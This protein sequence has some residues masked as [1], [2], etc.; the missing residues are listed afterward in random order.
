MVKLGKMNFRFATKDDESLVEKFCK[1]QN[2]S[3]NT[4]LKKMKWEWVLEEGAWTVATHK[5]KI[6]SIAGIHKL[7]EVSPDAYRCLFR[8]AQLPGYTLGTGRDIFK[9][10]IQLSQLLNLQINWA[11]EQNL[12]AEL[13][14][15]TN[16]NDDGGKSKR[17]NDTMMPLLARRGIWKLEQSMM[18]FNV[19][20]RL[21]RINVLKYME[22]RNLSLG[23]DNCTHQK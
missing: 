4:S 19:P 9:T 2:F 13:Y 7:P 15:S 14:I 20:Q 23:N 6:V 3:N 11:L 16:I 10:G 1:S 8:G 21:W 17:M 12:N 5:D 18:L 22:E